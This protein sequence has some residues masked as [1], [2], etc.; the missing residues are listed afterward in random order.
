MERLDKERKADFINMLKGFVVN[1][2][3]SW[4]IKIAGLVA[5]NFLLLFVL[6]CL[7]TF[8]Y[9]II[10]SNLICLLLTLHDRI[11][12][13]RLELLPFFPSNLSFS[14]RLIPLTTPDTN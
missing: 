14:E 13:R 1:Q 5:Q 12:A 9:P 4:Y 2:V 6:L 7:I 3:L 11:Q 8:L 10:F